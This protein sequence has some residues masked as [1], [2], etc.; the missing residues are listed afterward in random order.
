MDFQRIKN[1]AFRHK[2]ISFVVIISCVLSLYYLWHRGYFA[3]TRAQKIEALVR[4]IEYY[5]GYD[6][7]IPVP[8][9]WK[10]DERI[11]PRVQE[12]GD[13]IVPYLAQELRYSKSFLQKEAA[14]YLLAK[15]MKTKYS[16]SV[17]AEACR[18]RIGEPSFCA[19]AMGP[20]AMEYRVPVGSPLELPK[21]IESSRSPG[22]WRVYDWYDKHKE[23]LVDTDYGVG[24]RMPDNTIRPLDFHGVFV[25]GVTLPD[26]YYFCSEVIFV[27]SAN[28]AIEV[29]SLRNIISHTQHSRE[30]AEELAREMFFRLFAER[31]QKDPDFWP[32][33]PIIRQ[34]KSD[35]IR[36]YLI[37][38]YFDSEHRRHGLWRDIDRKS[39]IVTG[40][41]WFFHGEELSKEEYYVRGGYDMAISL[42]WSNENPAPDKA[43]TE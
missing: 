17:L 15:A 32:Y 29:R 1:V 18:D 43:S 16:L 40:E 36:R 3:I 13:E 5:K 31:V 39:N 7:D 14:N 38:G 26:E 41:R 25:Y 6:P 37:Q 2:F 8:F 19:E 10:A 4:N 22:N 27:Y 24:L 21:S 28:S 35:W 11:I 33:Y 42:P 34:V 20:A 9:T 23:R 30:N 12:Y